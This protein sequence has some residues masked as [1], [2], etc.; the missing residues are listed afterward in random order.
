MVNPFAY[1]SYHSGQNNLNKIRVTEESGP[2][3][4]DIVVIKVAVENIFFIL[5][6]ASF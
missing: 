4:W 1:A 6:C 2:M 3:S 5:F